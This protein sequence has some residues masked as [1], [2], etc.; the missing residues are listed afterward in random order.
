M[1]GKTYSS[2]EIDVHAHSRGDDGHFSNLKR[3]WTHGRIQ[4]LIHGSIGI[5]LLLVHGVKTS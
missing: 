2:I 3:V 5:L 1:R 4:H